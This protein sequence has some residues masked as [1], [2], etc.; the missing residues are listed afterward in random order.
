MTAVVGRLV[1][2]RRVVRM[3]VVPVW[4]VVG[5]LSRLVSLVRLVLVENVF[6]RFVS[7]SICALLSVV[8]WKVVLSVC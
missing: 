7:M 8:V 4:K 5:L 1:S 6:G 2:V 3:S